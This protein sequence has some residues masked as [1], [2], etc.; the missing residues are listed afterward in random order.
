MT[1]SNG[2]TLI[3]MLITIAVVTIGITGAFIAVQQGI[4]AI[5]FAKARFTAALLAQEGVEIVKN[6]RDTNLLEYNYVST[7][8]PWNEGLSPSPGPAVDF[9]VQY[10]DPKSLDPILSKPACSPNCDFN[11]LRFLKKSEHGFYNYSSGEDTRFKRK[12]HIENT[13]SDQMDVKII[14]YWTRREGGHHE[15]TLRQY[16]YHWW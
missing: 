4:S 5:D 14:V 13:S 1:N 12:V 9:E 15:L 3:E 2:F 16:L 11:G 6:I 8:T 10:T 7:S